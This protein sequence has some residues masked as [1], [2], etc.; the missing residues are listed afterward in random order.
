MT[1]DGLNSQGQPNKTF[2]G[3]LVNDT[4]KEIFGG[5]GSAIAA[6]SQAATGIK[7]SATDNIFSGSGSEVLYGPLPPVGV[8]ASVTFH[9]NTGDPGNP[10]TGLR[11]A[12]GEIDEFSRPNRVAGSNMYG[13]TKSAMAMYL[14][15]TT[16]DT[17]ASVGTEINTA[18]LS[19]SYNPTLT[20]VLGTPTNVPTML[21]YYKSGSGMVAPDPDWLTFDESW[22][23]A[24]DISTLG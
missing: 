1:Y 18:I 22:G 6:G 14:A 9:V 2:T 13:L 16:Q 24:G 23:I 19:Y 17:P 21:E 10:M 11:A 7:L 15:T 4:T 8:A 12:A 20:D 5:A 3:T